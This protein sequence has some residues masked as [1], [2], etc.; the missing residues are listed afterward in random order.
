M[1]PSLCTANNWG[2]EDDDEE[3]EG[4]LKKANLEMGTSTYFSF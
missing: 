1:D 2:G 3:R 4:E